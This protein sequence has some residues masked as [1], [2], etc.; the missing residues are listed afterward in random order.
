MLELSYYDRKR[1]HNLKYFTWVEQQDKSVE[2]LNQQWYAYPEFWD[3]IHRQVDEI[4]QLIH[5]FNARS[6]VP[7][8][9]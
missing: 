6:G 4:D 5:D 3:R 8:D 7:L 9:P 2:E 1:M